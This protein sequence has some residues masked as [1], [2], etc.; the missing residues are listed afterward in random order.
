MRTSVI[1]PAYNRADLTESLAETFTDGYQT[2]LV[3]NGSTDHTRDVYKRFDRVVTLPENVGFARGCN[4]GAKAASG[5]ILIFLNN[6]T[7]PEAGWVHPLTS[8]F[9][10]PSVGI[11]GAL[12]LYPDRT[13]QHAGV[14]LAVVGGVLTA[15]NIGRGEPLATKHLMSRQ[16]DAVTGACLA[17]R[18]VTWDQVGGF[19]DGYWNGYEDVDLCLTA[20]TLGWTVWYEPTS[21]VVHLESASG[22]ERWAGVHANVARLQERWCEQWQLLTS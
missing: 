21:V 18:R 20:R 9:T 8:A 15:F 2:V 17:I 14:H 19:D 4:E 22:P 11:A 10:D 16:V 13:V 5:D 7:L 1:V 12:L 6:D 3:D